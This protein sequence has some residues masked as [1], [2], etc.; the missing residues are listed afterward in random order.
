MNDISIPIPGLSGI[1][2]VTFNLA[3]SVG[4]RAG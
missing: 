3:G 2:S 4:L 1:S